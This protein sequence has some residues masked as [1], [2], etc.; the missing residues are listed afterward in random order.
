MKPLAKLDVLV[1]EIR[2]LGF[3]ALV[4]D[5]TLFVEGGG[6]PRPILCPL[7][8]LDY[9]RFVGDLRRYCRTLDEMAQATP[10]RGEAAPPAPT[11][12]SGKTEAARGGP[13][14]MADLFD[15]PPQ[16]RPARI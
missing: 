15:E 4:K 10:A 1:G 14:A 3:A 8:G 16:S 12:G 6:L 2:A 13:K 11:S 7:K 5:S 9:R